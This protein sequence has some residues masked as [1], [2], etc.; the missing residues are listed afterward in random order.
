MTSDTSDAIPFSVDISRMIELLASQIYP[1]P[2]ALLRE[3]VQNA[4]DA[5][6]LRK[7]AGDVFEPLIDVLIEPT[8]IT[9]SDNGIGMSRTELREH[10]WR[11]G[12]SSKN[13]DE[14][15]AAGVVGTFGIGAMANFGIADSLEVVSES[16]K[17]PERTRC[18]AE[19]KTLSV[20]DDCIKFFN[21]TCTGESGSVVIATMQTGKSI[22]VIQAVSYITE[23]VRFVEIPVRVNG[24]IV[25]Q[26]QFQ[27]AIPELQV[28]WRW[29]GVNVPLG[30]HLIADIVMTGAGSG[31]VRVSV[32][33]IKLSGQ[34]LIGQMVLR[35]GLNVVRTF[36]NRFG[37][38]TAQ[39]NSLY[40]LGGVADFLLLK[41]TAGREALTTEST[42]FLNMFG[43]PLDQLISE[44]LAE[45]P[46]ANN[47]QVFINWAAR[48]QRWDICGQL[49][50][51]LEP[52]DSATLID[53]VNISK[54]KPLLIYGGSDPGVMN[55]ASS[56]RPV[57]QLARNQQ[58]RQCESQYLTLYGT[59]ETLSD[60]PKVLN[61]LKKSELSMAQSAL[62]FR[63]SEILKSDYFIS[64]EIDFGTISHGLPILVINN[65]SLV[66]II[67]DP[68]ASNV[69]VLVEI[70]EKEYGV[71]GHL[72]KDFV[73]NVIFPKVSQ[74]VPSSTRQGTE[75]FLQTLQ[76]TRDV[77]EYE[78]SDLENL[79]SLWKDYLEGKIT[80]DQASA[81]VATV[82]RSYQVIEAAATGRVHDVVPDVAEGEQ[83]ADNNS[84]ASPDYS[85]M[86]SILRT[87]IETD[88]KLLTIED[89][90]PPLK[91]YSCFIAISK[92]I[93]E[94]RGEFFL[95][96]H[97]TSVVWGGQKALFIFE[98]H[99]GEVGLYYDI[100]LS[101]PVAPK[102]GGG[103]FE[104]CTIVM[105]NQTFIPV[106]SEIKDVF[107]P[108]SNETKRLEVRCDLLYIDAPR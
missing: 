72:A 102:S 77:F 45:R 13:T 106:P 51:R 5:I 15:R 71:F 29:N 73:R 67:L 38:A 17:T 9:V 14:A 8:R 97:R 60:E 19:R 31:E 16:T 36:R 18:L 61:L 53:L 66:R 6:M 105:K 70:Y 11:A 81:K 27:N 65:Q 47:S 39:I 99:S 87:D 98:H 26:E 30:T 37:L 52:G 20:T 44:H 91:G 41:P 86:P 95:Q 40:Q 96:P 108:K 7:Y 28:S 55:H 62:V 107:M 79:T 59:V 23:F 24:S 92:R 76:R 103:S 42:E 100:Q 32:S 83:F 85:A 74:L 35:Q 4:F 63:L 12:S 90:D 43:A 2:F 84:N 78:R 49:R 3:N 82:R 89:S 88:R 93:R 57:V 1:S 48:H 22:D 46:E 34:N 10:F 64:T 94:E 69:K 75:A 56:E 58:R 50:A 33:N 25:S 104:T 68:N 54:S 21:E 101:E 80:L